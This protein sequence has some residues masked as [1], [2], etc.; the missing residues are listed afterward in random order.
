MPSRPELFDWQALVAAADAALV[1]AKRA[2]RDG[3]VGL[4]DIADSEAAPVRV[5]LARSAE[6]WAGLPGWRVV[7]SRAPRPP[8]DGP[9]AESP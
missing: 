6:H 2:G 8:G 3:W 4:L 1:A 7:A 5:A 9:Q